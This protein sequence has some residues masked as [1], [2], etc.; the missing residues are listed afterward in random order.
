VNF[1]SKS[2]EETLVQ[3]YAICWGILFVLGRDSFESI[4]LDKSNRFALVS[5]H[6]KVIGLTN[7]PRMHGQVVAFLVRWVTLV[8]NSFHLKENSTLHLSFVFVF[9]FVFFSSDFSFYL[10]ELI[11]DYLLV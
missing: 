3:P 1:R 5:T 8:D 11:S 7:S 4:A 10:F 2:P 6:F 9:V